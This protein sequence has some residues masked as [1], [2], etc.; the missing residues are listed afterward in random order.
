MGKKNNNVIG[1]KKDKIGEKNPDFAAVK[2]K[3]K[4]LNQDV[5]SHN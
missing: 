5:K 4:I 1:P 2:W 3:F